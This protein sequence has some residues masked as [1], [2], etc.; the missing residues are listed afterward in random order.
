MKTPITKTTPRAFLAGVACAAVTTV[1]ASA[2]AGGYVQT[3]L[4]TDD[5]TVVAAEGFSPAT[6]VDPK[7]VN[8]WGMDHA[9]GGPW[10]V[11][12]AGFP[13]AAPGPSSNVTS[14]NGAGVVAAIN[15]QSAQNGGGGSGGATGLVY[16]G[17]SGFNLPTGG[18][19]LY[20]LSNLDG[21]ISGWNPAQGSS[22]QQVVPGRTGGNTA[23]Y[24]GLDL[25]EYGGQTYLYAA[26]HQTGK[27]DVFD[28]SFTPHSFGAN[29]FV[30]PLSNPNNLLPFNV[31]SIGGNIWV[32]Y[33]AAS[34]A[35][36]P[37]GSGFVDEFTA[38]GTFLERFATG[39]DLASPWAI[40]IAPSNF[41]AFSGDVL[42]GNFTHGSYGYI[43]AYRLSDGAFEGLL[44]DNGAPIAMEGLWELAFG[45]G[46]QSGATS[47]LYFAA[48]IDSEKHG[49]FGD[50]TA[51]PEPGAWTLMLLGL[52][53][54]GFAMRRRRE[55]AAGAA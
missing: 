51:V 20:L 7:L 6:F 16:N 27:I 46:G 33:A 42:I 1:A 18:P 14:Y 55:G 43:S 50:I 29:A 17:G 28:S 8:P 36:A 41:G 22:A 23:K 48:G 49:L 11:A 30:D 24:S 32:T 12:D 13:T 3:N 25:G 9:P 21:S 10:V 45:G 37:L 5:P 19:A 52:A 54:T 34:A 47:A 4:V 35:G 40:V 26:N 38:N 53:A 44:S 39:G 31:E 15:F 2:S